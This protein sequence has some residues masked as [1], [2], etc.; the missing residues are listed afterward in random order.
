VHAS[1]IWTQIADWLITDSNEVIDKLIE[2]GGTQSFG[3]AAM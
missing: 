3:I 1:N 2:N